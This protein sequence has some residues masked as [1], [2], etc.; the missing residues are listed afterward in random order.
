MIF[1]SF[2]AVT[3]TLQ[4]PITKKKK[5]KRVEGT[6]ATALLTKFERADWPLYKVMS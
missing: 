2:S 5:K 3:F 6:T 1:K 4:S